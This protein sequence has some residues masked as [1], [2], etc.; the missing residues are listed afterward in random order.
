MAM[1]IE[2]PAGTFEYKFAADS[3]GIQEELAP[4]GSCVLT[5]GQFTNRVLTVSGDVNLP[6]VCWASCSACDNPTGPFNVTFKVDMR[7]VTEAYTTPEVNGTFNNWCGG[8][9]PMADPDEDGIWELVVSLPADTFEFK[10][11]ADS[12][13]IQE[14]LASGSSCTVT[15]D[16][17]TNRQLIV[18]G[19]SVLNAVCWGSCD[20]CV[21]GINDISAQEEL[22][23]FPNPANEVL[24]LNLKEAATSNVLVT[25]TDAT[26]RTIQ[27]EVFA[28]AK[29]FTITTNT[30]AGGLYFVRINAGNTILTRPFMVNN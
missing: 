28:P 22:V 15:T 19:E 6:E 11:A 21:V 26:G 27:S 4:G 10:F 23:L 18:T 8:C 30:L 25:V 16:N 29:Q 5:T 13:G 24:T 2:L 1:M 3:W 17:F 20:P 7:D 12:W 14:N 9:A